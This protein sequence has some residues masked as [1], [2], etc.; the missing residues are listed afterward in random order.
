MTEELRT[1]DLMGIK[2]YVAFD[3][4]RN[5]YCG[6]IE[7]KTHPLIRRTICGPYTTPELCNMA[8]KNAFDSNKV[9]P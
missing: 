1:T 4:L 6:W 9:K 5:G 2:V 7:D 8:L 3:N